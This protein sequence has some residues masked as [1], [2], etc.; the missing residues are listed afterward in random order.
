VALWLHKWRAGIQWSFPLH[1]HPNHIVQPLTQAAV[2]VYLGLYSPW[3]ARY[4][5]LILFQ[6][7][8]A[9]VFEMLLS[10]AKYR[11]FR[12]GFSVFPIVLSVNLII[13]FRPEYFYLQILMVILAVFSKHFI[14]WSN[15]RHIF[16][17]SGLG[18]IAATLFL[19]CFRFK[20]IYLA[21]IIGTYNA[22][23]PGIFLFVLASGWVVQLVGGISLISLG[24]LVS[25][26]SLYTVS[27]WVTGFPLINRWIDPAILVGVTLLVTDPA[28]TPRNRWPQ[29][30]FGLLYG[31]GIIFW[32]G[33]LSY[34]YLPGYFA[35]VMALPLLNLIAPNMDKIGDPTRGVFTHIFRTT[36]IQT[37]VYS[38]VFLLLV[39]GTQKRRP[40]LPSALHSKIWAEGAKR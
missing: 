6:L 5:P 15:G 4:L 9:F 22:A 23:R 3:V 27:A 8:F 35:K 13:W 16:N 29:F 36:R 31:A 39:P 7:V 21:E 30:M 20:P 18:L 17:P 37:A 11:S 10:L 2:F 34:L 40:S 12:I 38:I 1:L 32:Y 19:F 28:T 33:V 14:R 24:A 25:L 26:F